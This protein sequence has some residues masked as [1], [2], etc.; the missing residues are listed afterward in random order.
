MQARRYVALILVTFMTVAVVGYIFTRRSEPHFGETKTGVTVL[1]MRE[2]LHGRLDMFKSDCGRYPTEEEGLAA[3]Y[4]RPPSCGDQWKGP[5][6]DR[7][8]IDAWNREIK[9]RLIEGRPVL[10]SYGESTNGMAEA[11]V[12]AKPPER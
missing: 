10:I 1:F 6:V 12:V 5:Y 4:E 9:Y 7:I 2:V 3:L 11:I 8:P